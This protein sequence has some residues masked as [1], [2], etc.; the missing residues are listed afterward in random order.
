[1]AAE[2]ALSLPAVDRDQSLTH[3]IDSEEEAVQRHG[4]DRRSGAVDPEYDVSW[5]FKSVELHEHVTDLLL[6][7]TPVSESKAG[8]APGLYSQV[9]KQISGYQRESRAGVNQGLDGYPLAL[10][11]NERNGVEE[12]AH[13]LILLGI[14]AGV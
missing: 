3:R 9:T 2:T 4:A 1:V 5:T 13:I 10:R 6:L 12:P 14:L 11:A 7:N 8:A